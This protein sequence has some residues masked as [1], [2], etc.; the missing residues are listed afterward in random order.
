MLA[1]QSQQV[2]WLRTM[3]LAVG[4]PRAHREARLM[5]T[6]KMAAAIHEGGRLMLGASTKS[7]VK[8][9]VSGS[10]PTSVAFRGSDTMNL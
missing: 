7:V 4:G 6:E 2:I 8:R 1:I 5:V 3:K 10:T 9:Y